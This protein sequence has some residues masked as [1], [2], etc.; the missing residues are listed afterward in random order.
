MRIATDG[1]LDSEA[2][3][4]YAPTRTATLFDPS[5][6]GPKTIWAEFRDRAGNVKQDVLSGHRPSQRGLVVQVAMLDE[7]VGALPTR[8]AGPDMGAGLPR[9]G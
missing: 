4:I 9:V 6:D 8:S 5:I 1:A 7:M 3:E 2:W